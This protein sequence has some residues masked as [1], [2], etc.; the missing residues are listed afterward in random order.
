MDSALHL[1]TKPRITIIQTLKPQETRVFTVRW[2]VI[3]EDFVSLF[4]YNEFKGKNLEGSE[5]PTLK[6]LNGEAKLDEKVDLKRMEIDPVFLGCK[7]QLATDF[8]LLRP[9][10][11]EWLIAPKATGKSSHHL[12]LKN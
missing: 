2:P 12:S 8:Q 6:H 4:I 9:P 10:G 5:A 3:Y 11:P 1:K 7:L